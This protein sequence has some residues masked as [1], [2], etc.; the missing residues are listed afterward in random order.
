M[1]QYVVLSARPFD[2]DN[3]RRERIQGVKLSYINP[4]VKQ[5][6]VEGFEPMLVTV[7]MEFMQSITEVPGR[8]DMAFEMVTGPKNKPAL[9]LSDMR[10]VEP[11]IL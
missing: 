3:D 7:P 4:S 1:S 6:G 10:F 9:K 11:V 2:F 5:E 8:Y